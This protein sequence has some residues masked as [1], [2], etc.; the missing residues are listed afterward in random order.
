MKIY[1]CKECGFVCGQEYVCFK[2]R[3]NEQRLIIN[4][5]RTIT[6]T[7]HKKLVALIDYFYGDIETF[8]SEMGK[9]SDC[10]DC[11]A[12]TCPRDLNPIARTAYPA[13]CKQRIIDWYNE[14]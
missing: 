7:K 1:K 2:C 4:T 6:E 9:F 3:K 11:P 5:S 14:V 13:Y 10:D 12:E 8:M